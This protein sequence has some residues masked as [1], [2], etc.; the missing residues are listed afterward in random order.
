METWEQSRVRGRR[1]TRRG[2][3]GGI[4]ASAAVAILAACGGSK[5][6]EAPKATAAGAAAT[7]S[8]V[9]AASTPATVAA[10][11][12]TAAPVATTA[13]ATSNADAGSIAFSSTQLTP[14]QQAESM[15]K[16]ILANF[17]GKVDFLPEDY[18]PF[19]DR[20][21]AGAQAGKQTIS[22][23]GGLHG[24]MVPFGNDGLLED[25]T[26]LLTKLGDRGFPKGFIDLAR[27][28]TTDKVFYIPWMQATYIM[29][30]N[31]KALQYLPQGAKQDSLTYA[32]LT[33]WGVNIQ[34][35]TGQR[36][37]GFPGGPKGLLHRFFQGYSYPAYTNSV[38]VQFRSPEAVQMWTDFKALWATANP[39]S[40]SYAEI[41]TPLQAEEIWVGWDHVAGWINV[42][43]DQ[44]ND[45]VTFPAPAGPKGR[46]FMPVLAGLAIPKGAPNRPGAELLIDYLTQQQQQI[47]TVKEVAF[48]PVTSAAIPT[49]LSPGIKLEADGVKAQTAAPDALATLLPVGLG[50][51]GGDFNKV[52]LDSFQRI[53]LNKEAVQ[54]V[55]DDQA[56]ILQGIMND[57]KAPC[58]APDPTSAGV[59]MVK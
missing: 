57:T 40:T 37:L 46:S 35:A 44:P 28:G 17:K 25:L 16:T 42:L 7:T 39:Q 52:Y 34:K 56:K 32:Q 18:G 41:S 24:D 9:S 50:S 4:A 10:T 47:T 31:K 23:I 59:C 43:K 36:R 13:S 55:L 6:T 8:P 2:F 19:N 22:I 51:K 53:V 5:A 29:G 15:R 14:V 58:W 20:I 1:L 30:A 3:L 27:L 11:N 49:D 21:R 33:E 38:V 12:G 54:T 26:P 45:F 48:F